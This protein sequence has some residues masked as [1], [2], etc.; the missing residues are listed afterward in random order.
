MKKSIALFALAIPLVFTS[1]FK[2]EPLN[3]ECDIEQVILHSTAADKVFFNPS[4]TIQEVLFTDSVVS[5]NVR[6]GA[7]LETVTPE[8]KLTPGATL[9]CIEGDIARG[10]A[11]YMV[12]SEDG[13]W[14]RRYVVSLIPTAVTVSDT[15][16]FD[17]EHFE[18]D[19]TY[20]KFYIWHNL[21]ADGSLGNDWATGNGGFKLSMSTAQPDDYPTV[22]IVGMDGYAVKLTTR[23]TG[24]FGVMVNKRIASGNMF[25]GSFDVANALKDAMKATRFGIPFDKKPTKLTG[26]YKYKRGATYQDINGKPVSGKTD[27][28]DIYAVFYRNHDAAGNPVT[29]YGDDVKTNPNIVAMASVTPIQVTN[30]W[31]YFDVVFNY[32]KEL[33]PAVLESR[34]YSLTIVFSSSIDGAIFQGAVGSELCVD[35]VR[36]ICTREE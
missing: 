33:D 10:K 2:D 24:P 35:K 7:P 3:T 18:L 6:S 29:L 28:G 1:C 34:G 19:P 36:L 11:T 26:Y 22:P 31:T 15:L 12:T 5:V 14:N 16:A 4:D 17:L 21:L 27:N 13:N 9:K 8:F 30:E 23:D 25:L 20:H 32:S